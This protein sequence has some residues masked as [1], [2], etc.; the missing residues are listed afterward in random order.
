MLPSPMQMAALRSY[1][2]GSTSHVAGALQPSLWLLVQRQLD[3]LS[4]LSKVA[5]VGRRVKYSN[6]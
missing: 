2:A 1:R 4:A 3:D 5:V 6:V